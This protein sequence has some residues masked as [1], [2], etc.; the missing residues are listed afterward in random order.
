MDPLF[1]NDSCNP[2]PGPGATCVLG[3]LASYAINVSDA[4]TAAAGINF[5]REHNIR[6]T[7]KNTGHD[8]MGR[9][10]G[11]GSLG[12]WTHNLK[13]ISF[14][15]YNS[16]FYKGSAVRLGAGVQFAELYQA[17]SEN[18]FR[19]VGGGCPTVGAAGG[20]PQGGGHGPLGALH[21]LGSDN[22]LEFEVVTAAGKHITASPTNNPDLYWALSGG[23][24]GN[25]AVAISVTVKAY[26]DGP[27]AG[28]VFSFSNTDYNTYW[29]GVSAW[30]N[31]LLVL[32]QVPGLTSFW[33]LSNEAATLLW[34]VYPD[35]TADDVSA[36]LAPLHQ[37]L[38]ALNITLTVDETQV[39]PTF[40]EAYEVFDGSQTYDTNTSLAGRLV[41]RSV[42][43]NTLPELV[44]TLR[45]IVS[46]PDYP[47]L[48]SI[49]AA[50]V[51]HQRVGNNA[52]SNAVLPAWRD[53]LF[54]MT[55]GIGFPTT[56]T[57]ADL[58]L[59]EVQLNKWQDDMRAVTPGGGT[60]MNE[61]TWD[62]PNWKEDYF[63]SNYQRLLALKK[64]YDP[65]SVFWA[66]AAVGSD[67]YWKLASDGRLC[68]V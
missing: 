40:Y 62:N 31:Y 5:A 29:A 63:G 61:A 52:A 46:N 55:I 10:A 35:K 17:A 1:L 39:L 37:E 38:A 26:K 68:R 41:S 11:Q 2:F 28:S 25:Y 34:A 50:N 43:Q 8:N 64:K 15:D 51:S 57:P 60:Y 65:N 4:A 30:L 66:N 13:E 36:V 45:T 32:D 49:I 47:S 23:G 12:L 21:G 19:V 59:A 33:A 9:S 44:A 7:V 24:G 53:S 18:G 3:D 16:S 58:S 54:H 20:Y 48:I 22:T 42:V 6:L 56:D 67:D 27:V 14:F